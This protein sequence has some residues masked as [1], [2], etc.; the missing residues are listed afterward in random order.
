MAKGS[1]IGGKVIKD[2]KEGTGLFKTAVEDTKHVEDLKKNRRRRTRQN[3][4][5]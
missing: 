5:A 3:L 4:W 2:V 1:S